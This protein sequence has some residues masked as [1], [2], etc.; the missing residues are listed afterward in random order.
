MSAEIIQGPGRCRI[1]L[2]SEPDGYH[3]G[4][5]AEGDRAW[6]G[7]PV[8]ARSH[9]SRGD[10]L[11]WAGARIRTALSDRITPAV[12]AWLTSLAPAQPD[13]FAA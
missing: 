7:F 8:D 12:D 6:V 11:S 9:A 10:A 2:A 5:D 4:F 3:V 13:L 1:I